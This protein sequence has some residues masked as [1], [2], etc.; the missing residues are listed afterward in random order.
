MLYFIIGQ[1]QSLGTTS[2]HWCLV[3]YIG[4]AL[5]HTSGNQIRAAAKYHRRS[6]AI[7][8]KTQAIDYLIASC[9]TFVFFRYDRMMNT[10]NYKLYGTIPAVIEILHVYNILLFNKMVQKTIVVSCFVVDVW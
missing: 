1:G 10:Y 5:S 3:Y 9:I 4:I 2:H 6:A 7:Q 8:T